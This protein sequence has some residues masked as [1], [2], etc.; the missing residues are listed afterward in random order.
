MT[1]DIE[2]IARGKGW[3]KAKSDIFA[4]GFRE[5]CNH[6]EV[7]S[8][9]LGK[10]KL[11][12]HLYRAQNRFLD[13]IFEGLSRDVHD[14]K[15][16][17]SRQL[18]IS[19]VSRALTLFWGGVHEGLQ[20]YMIL[21]TGPHKE[22]A[23][24]ELIGMIKSLPASYKFPRIVRE[25][26]DLL[27]LENDTM[28]NFA[29]AGI[30]ERKNSGTLG[31]GSGVNFCHGSEMA[32]WA[33]GENIVAFLNTLAHTFPDRLYCWESTGRGPGLWDD[34]WEEAKADEHHQAA[35]FSGWWARDDQ[36]IERDDP[37]FER[38]GVAPPSP[39]EAK[40]IALVRDMYGWQITPEQLA[41]ARRYSDPL[42]QDESDGQSESTDDIYRAREQA[43]SEQDSSLTAEAIF[44]H[45]ESVN[46]QREKYA[47]NEYKTYCFQA[48]VEFTDMRAMPAPN[49]RSAELKVWKEPEPHC[50]YIVSADVAFGTNE[51]NDRSAIEVNLAYSDG[52]DQVAEFKSPLYTTQ[53][54][55]WVILALAAWY[56]GESSE[57]HIIIE[58]NGPGYSVWDEIQSV[59]K[60]LQNGYYQSRRIEPEGL[61]NIVRNVRNFIYTRPDATSQSAGSRQWKTAAGAGPSGKVRLMERFRDFVQNEMLHIRS[62]SLLREMGT[63]TRVGD[64]I[65]AQGSSNHDDCVMA[66]SFAVRAW[67]DRVR[68][69]LIANKKTRDNE[70]ARKRMS[71]VDKANLFRQNQLQVFLSQKQRQR[72]DELRML[73][74]RA[75]RGR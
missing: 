65:E 63:V 29:A 55:A 9:E 19:T 8:K 35:L 33:G 24:L 2:D 54:F 7:N 28:F 38:Y 17:K 40:K 37:D 26:R 23:R 52:L 44:F 36:I 71:V 15:H 68:R 11:G 21:D 12:G 53:Q 51:N 59:K 1:I 16:M 74:R 3:T 58:L 27:L 13:F 62:Y 4:T 25:N 31:R 67:E 69:T 57:V 30:S 18:G 48:G 10:I 22:A 42:K 47:S 43:W 6:V 61:S 56:A 14:F 64:S 34:M 5:F 32:S 49:P 75:W 72:Q 70:A 20:G 50:T 66:E 46:V 73:R 39:N 41:W 60:N 45:P